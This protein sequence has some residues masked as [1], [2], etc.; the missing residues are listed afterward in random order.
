[1]KL[2]FLR[3]RSTES[4]R[5]FESI[6]PTQS[7]TSAKSIVQ[8]Y[9]NSGSSRV[10]ILVDEVLLKT[11]GV[12]NNV[13]SNYPSAQAVLTNLYFL[14]NFGQDSG[15]L[16]VHKVVFCLTAFFRGVEAQARTIKFRTSKVSLLAR[17]CMVCA[18]LTT[19]HREYQRYLQ[20]AQ[21]RGKRRHSLPDNAPPQYQPPARQQA[22]QPQYQAPQRSRSP[23]PASQHAY[24]N[25]PP[26]TRMVD[27][28]INTGTFVCMQAHVHS[29]H[30]LHQG[31]NTPPMHS[32]L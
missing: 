24:Y 15:N 8:K 1:M 32:F 6:F 9:R 25:S 11:D 30:K 10:A 16:G 12:N 28:A 2:P 29:T 20:E 27:E 4:A 21:G 31:P 14:R 18:Q 3:G 7:E 19:P 5:K 17:S 23:P 22:P 13:S 26:L